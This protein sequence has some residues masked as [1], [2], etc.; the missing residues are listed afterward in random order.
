MGG[1]AASDLAD[2]RTTW[3]LPWRAGN[4]RTSRRP[5]PPFSPAVTTAITTT[6]TSYSIKRN[7]LV[8]ASLVGIAFAFQ[9]GLGLQLPLY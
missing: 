1:G 7:L 6:G 2:T 5:S 4:Y 9:K 8:S 3:S